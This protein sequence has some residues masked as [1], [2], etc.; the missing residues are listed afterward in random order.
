MRTIYTI[1][2]LSLLLSAT[3]CVQIFG[4]HKQKPLSDS[5]IESKSLRYQFQP[6]M[7]M[8]TVKLNAVENLKD[9]NLRHDLI[10]PLQLWVLAGD[11]VYCNTVNCYCTVS[12]LLN[13]KWKLDDLYRER[14]VHTHL[15]DNVAAAQTLRAFYGLP[16]TADTIA[17]VNYSLFMGRQNRRFLRQTRKLLQEHPSLKP[18]YINMDNAYKP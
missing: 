7:A 18:Y 4:I 5:Q 9:E 8:D 1:I 16:A 13:L 12:P 17:I 3:S 10:Q 2:I 6:Y 15:E 11:S 14:T